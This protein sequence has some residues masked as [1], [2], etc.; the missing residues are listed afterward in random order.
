V[1]EMPGADGTKLYAWHNIEET[2]AHVFCLD[3]RKMT[4]LAGMKNMP[5]TESNDIRRALNQSGFDASTVR[6]MLAA[7]CNSKTCAEDED[8]AR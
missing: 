3:C 2:G 8:E 7:H 1:D 6:M 5:G 4:T